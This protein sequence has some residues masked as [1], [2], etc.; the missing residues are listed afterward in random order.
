MTA[1]GS[2]EI[3]QPIEAVELLRRAVKMFRT[4]YGSKGAFAYR[5]KEWTED[6]E[7]F[8]ADLSGSRDAADELTAL[9]DGPDY[10]EEGR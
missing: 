3:G 4:T 10:W 2:D 9:W 1:A 7:R 5:A 6:A 8:L